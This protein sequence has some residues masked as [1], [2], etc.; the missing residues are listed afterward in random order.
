MTTLAALAERAERIT[1]ATELHVTVGPSVFAD[2]ST[3][4]PGRY[5][6]IVR[7]PHR[8]EVSGCGPL[9]AEAA[10]GYLD[11]MD[12]MADLERQL[13]GAKAAADAFHR[14]FGPPRQETPAHV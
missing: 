14:V 13:A 9:T 7:G 3:P 10:A 6:V 2:G 4:Q 1:A 8:T 5:D 11:R 12:P